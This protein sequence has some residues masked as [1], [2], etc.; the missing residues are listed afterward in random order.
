MVFKKLWRSS[1]VILT[2]SPKE[3]LRV[4]WRA[5]PKSKE[6]SGHNFD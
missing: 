5:P 1:L 6:V 3:S 2:K 4:G